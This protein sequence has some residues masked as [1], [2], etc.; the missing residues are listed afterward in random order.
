MSYQ[1]QQHESLEEGLRRVAE[2]QIDKALAEIDDSKLSRHDTVHQVRKRC[3]KLRALARLVRSAFPEYQRFNTLYRDAARELSSIRDAQAVIET[4]DDLLHHFDRQLDPGAFQ[5]I[6]NELVARRDEAHAGVEAIDRRIA[7]VRDTISSSRNDIEYWS[8]EADG[9]LILGRGV[10]KTYRRAGKAR[11]EAADSPTT[12]AFHEWRKRI[13]YH[14]YHSRLLQRC[15]PAL[16][17]PWASEMH[18]LSDMLGD[19]HDL[20]VLHTMLRK[21]PDRFADRK[22][23]REFAS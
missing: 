16:I 2:E 12:E 7:R 23:L 1:L 5:P 15:W 6:R 20:A 13:K 18:R 11:A 21:G 9:G 14:W 17:K 10:K 8:L 22:R 3:K 4:F 19:E